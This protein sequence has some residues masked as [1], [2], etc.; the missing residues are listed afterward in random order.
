M[1]R[2]L[3]E[4]NCKTFSTSPA[5]AKATAGEA[6]AHSERRLF[7]GLA[8]AA[9]IAWKLTVINAIPMAK[10]P[11][12]QNPPMYGRPVLITLEPI[13]KEPTRQ[14]GKK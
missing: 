12:V 8:T 9:F 6:V 11:A 14:L 13:I 1:I 2:G 4:K 7:T 5:F 10:A 3:Q